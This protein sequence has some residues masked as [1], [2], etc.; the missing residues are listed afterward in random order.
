VEDEDV[1]EVEDEDVQEVESDDRDWQQ[2][3][4]AIQEIMQRGTASERAEEQVEPEAVAPEDALK[5]PASVSEPEQD[6][7]P[8]PVRESAFDKTQ[9]ILDDLLNKKTRS[10]QE[11]PTLAKDISDRDVEVEEAQPDELGAVVNQEET[12]VV[13][14]PTADAKTQRVGQQGPEYSVSYNQFA[15]LSIQVTVLKNEIKTLKDELQILRGELKPQAISSA[16]DQEREP[17]EQ[18]DSREPTEEIEAA[19]VAVEEVT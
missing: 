2:N 15:Q 13:T 8:E 19:A 14:V 3:Y 10:D 1:S 5:T 4:E 11:S 16:P 7:E 17:A 12:P 18:G 9:R 6:T